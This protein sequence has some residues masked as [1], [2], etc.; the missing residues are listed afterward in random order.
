MHGNASELTADYYTRY[1]GQAP[2][3][4]PS[5]LH[6]LSCVVRGGTVNSPAEDCRAAR[7]TSML[8]GRPYR[9][10][11]FRVVV[12]PDDRRPPNRT[13]ATFPAQ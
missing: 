3:V 10:V 4:D 5:F 7:R 12:D 13:P 6:G 1:L 8:H 11:G 2:R 9:D